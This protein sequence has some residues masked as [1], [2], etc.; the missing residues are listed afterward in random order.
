MH[1]KITEVF[2]RRDIP[3][4]NVCY[5]SVFHPPIL[6][7]CVG[8]ISGWQVTPLQFDCLHETQLLHVPIIIFMRNFNHNNYET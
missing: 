5:R 1:L 4:N 3:Y 6:F 7:P 8:G 2:K